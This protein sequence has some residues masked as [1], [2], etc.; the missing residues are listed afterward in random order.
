MMVPK[1]F[2]SYSHDDEK[3]KQWVLQLST[4]L[5]ANGVDVILDRWNLR[6]GQDLP[7]FMEQGLSES[8]RVVCVCSEQYVS[9]SNSK[10]GGVGYEKQIITAELLSD[11][12]SRWV[13]PLVRNNKGSNKVPTFLNGRLYIDFDDDA[14]YETRYEE[15]L[16][17]LLDAPVLPI[18]ELGTNPFQAAKEHVEQKF[19]PS[20]ERYVSPSLTG[21]VTFDYS[22]NN[23]MYAIGQGALLFELKFSKASD[24]SI[25][26]YNDAPSVE[27][28]A[29]VKDKSQIN[30]IE[31][32]RMYNGSSI[33]RTIGLQ[34]IATVMNKNGF[35]AAIKVLDVKDDSRNDNVDEITF[36]YVIQS[37]GTPAFIAQNC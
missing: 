27:T 34:Q 20:S 21:Q 16:R 31:D 13:I 14:L 12:N 28:I 9:K 4:R 24:T 3:H 5:R 30:E 17:D 15:L 10:V 11:L 1:V 23:G 36:E 32:A 7:A 18:P 19:F 29:L 25:H 22:N 6:L 37:N 26:L 33:T 2:I 8:Q 35:F